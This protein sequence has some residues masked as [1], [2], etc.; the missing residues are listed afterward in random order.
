M[1]QVLAR[2]RA[3]GASPGKNCYQ[4]S[5]LTLRVHK[6]VTV[7]RG[8]GWGRQYN[9]SLPTSM[10]IVVVESTYRVIEI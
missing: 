2:S 4:D 9:L 1:G 7:K 8:F 10:A 6:S 5:L 3:K